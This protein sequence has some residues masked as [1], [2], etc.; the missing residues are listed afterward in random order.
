MQQSQ[1]ISNQVICIYKKK[2]IINFFYWF[3]IHSKTTDNNDATV[4]TVVHGTILGID[5]PFPISNPNACLDS[6]VTCPLNKGSVYE[7]TA[8]FPILKAYPKVSPVSTI[9]KALILMLFFFV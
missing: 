2:Q 7:Y 3:F 6:G 9:L 4:T 8:T 5:M 1:L